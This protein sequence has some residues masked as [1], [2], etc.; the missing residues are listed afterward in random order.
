[1]L[2]IF[3][4]DDKNFFYERYVRFHIQNCTLHTRVTDPDS[5]FEIQWES[6]PVFEIWSDPD[7]GFKILSEP[8]PV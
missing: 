8:D 5:S 6:D 7:T 4:V 3:I 1:M 2:I